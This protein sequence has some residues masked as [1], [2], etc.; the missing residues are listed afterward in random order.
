[1]AMNVTTW[2]RLGAIVVL[3]LAV[4][5]VALVATAP[6][7]LVNDEL[8]YNAL[9][10]HLVSGGALGD[11]GGR[12]PG[13]VLFYAAL[14]GILGP[15]IQLARAG[16]VL[17]SAAT[18]PV[19][20]ALGRSFGGVRTGLLAALLAALYPGLVA[21]SHGLWSETLYLFAMLSGLALVIG[22]RER[23]VAWKLAAA[24]ALFGIGALTREVGLL[25]AVFTAGFLAFESR[26]RWKPGLARAAL[27]LAP[28][29]LITLPWGAH[30]YA[31]TG[32][33]ALASRT[34]WFNLY[35]G[36]APVPEVGGWRAHPW[37]VYETL[38]RT[39][40]E[41]EAAARRLALEAIRE[42][43][44]WWPLEKLGELRSFLAPTSLAVAR[45][46]VDADAGPIRVVAAGRWSYRFRVEAL[47]SAGFRDGMALACVAAYLIVLVPGVAGLLLAR[48]R[49]LTRLFGLCLLAHVLPPLLAF[50]LSRFRLPV[51]PVFMIGAAWLAC[52]PSAAWRG[53]STRR[54]LAAGLL[55]LAA[56]GVVAS[57]W[58]AAFS[59][60]PR[61][62]AA[63]SSPFHTAY[64][65]RPAVLGSDPW[66][67]RRPWT[68]S[69]LFAGE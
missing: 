23:P 7:G 38:G 22:H 53:A 41:R 56:L 2:Q 26:P 58:D 10:E 63:G 30:V 28:V 39:R 29:A 21:Y 52:A 51:M 62:I 60:V 67:L 8:L 3:A 40:S 44:P 66:E 36:N 37:H 50:A 55:A 59:S 9:A 49:A 47:D 34:S 24:G 31:T 48:E 61:K 33:L 27:L 1:M 32:D 19:V 46:R 15:S 69:G 25:V 6:T 11:A 64:A 17:L 43:M 12:P 16:N 18:V 35:V 20:F 14:F 54:R 13:V 42:R 68:L 65:G 45:L 57:R 4:R 5:V